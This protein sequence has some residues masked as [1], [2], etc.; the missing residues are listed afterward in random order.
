MRRDNIS[1][2][3]E[4]QEQEICEKA[5][6]FLDELKEEGCYGMFFMIHTP[7]GAHYVG[8]RCSEPKYLFCALEEIGKLLGLPSLF[9]E[10]KEQQ[11]VEGSFIEL[12]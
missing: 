10:E 11:V 4:T 8:S 9:S 12:D 2:I 5:R 7:T 6:G 3:E 1:E